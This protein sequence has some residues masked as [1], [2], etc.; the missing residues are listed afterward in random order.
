M[1][2]IKVTQCLKRCEYYEKSGGMYKKKI[3]G[4]S[5]QIEEFVMIFMLL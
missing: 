3:R 5:K 2:I 1:F 4:V